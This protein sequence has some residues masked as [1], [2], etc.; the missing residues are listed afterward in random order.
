MCKLPDSVTGNEAT[1]GDI[2]MWGTSVMDDYRKLCIIVKLST[3]LEI[4]SRDN[5]F[6]LIS[7]TNLQGL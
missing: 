3:I 1:P 4:S 5:R 6:R 2:P 7:F